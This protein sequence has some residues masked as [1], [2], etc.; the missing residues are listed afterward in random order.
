MYAKFITCIMLLNLYV[1]Q[2]ILKFFS[3][4]KMRTLYLHKYMNLSS[5]PFWGWWAYVGSKMG[6]LVINRM[7]LEIRLISPT[8]AQVFVWHSSMA[9]RPELLQRGMFLLLW[10]FRSI[11][12]QTIT[13]LT[14]LD[15]RLF[16]WFSSNHHQMTLCWPLKDQIHVLVNNSLQDKCKPFNWT[17]WFYDA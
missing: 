3:K 9:Y 10:Y 13:W 2:I 6:Y 8:L 4:N 16:D 15:D 11:D 7:C 17:L 12:I 1:V 14:I 5:F